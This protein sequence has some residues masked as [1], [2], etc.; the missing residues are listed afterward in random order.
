V[1]A[2]LNNIIRNKDDLLTDARDLLYR[3]T[4]DVELLAKK[5][6]DADI[7]LEEYPQQ[8]SDMTA[9]KEQRDKELEEFRNAA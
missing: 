2:E 9:E 5:F 7:Q 3:C 4:D 8:I 6:E 1:P